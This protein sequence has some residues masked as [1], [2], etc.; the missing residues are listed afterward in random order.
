MY[1]LYL[2]VIL[3]CKY[4]KF[5][6]EPFVKFLG[7]TVMFVVFIILISISGFMHEQP[8]TKFSE[9][10][11]DYYFNYTTFIQ[12]NKPNSYPF[13]DFYM[14]YDKPKRSDIVIIVFVVG[15]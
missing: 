13:L 7:H 15:N 4:S 6:N 3:H 10:L 12:T 5:A 14:R 8:R 2:I 1:F 11:L 9:F